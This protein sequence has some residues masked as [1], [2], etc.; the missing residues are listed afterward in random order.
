MFEGETLLAGKRAVITAGGNGFQL[1]DFNTGASLTISGGSVMTTGGNAVKLNA[2]IG[3]ASVQLRGATIKGMCVLRVAGTADVASS[4]ALTRVAG[5]AVTTHAV[6][7]VGAFS[8]ALSVV[9]G[10][11][12]AVAGDALHFDAHPTKD[13]ATF[14]RYFKF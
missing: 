9:G 12:S 6:Q 13:T 7:V 10:A 11:L 3:T 4:V 14:A 1:Q 8:G 2:L 5:E